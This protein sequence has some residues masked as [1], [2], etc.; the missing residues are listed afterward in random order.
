MKKLLFILSFCLLNLAFA[1]PA[2]AT[3]YG[4]G[5]KYSANENNSCNCPGSP[6]NPANFLGFSCC[7]WVEKN[8]LCVAQAPTAAPTN[9]KNTNDEDLGI[10]GEPVTEDTL[11]NLNPLLQQST[12]DQ[13]TLQDLSTPAGVINRVLTFLFPIAGFILF[14]MIVVG[15]FEM[16]SG[17][18]NKKSIESGKQRVV[19]AIVGFI[20]LFCA[21]WIAQLV[22]R[23]LGVRILG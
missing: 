23:I 11:N 9:N 7:G 15:G 21:Y 14:L 8:Y 3:V 10:V 4:C 6:S 13:K 5:Q 16:M 1:K 19:A 20:L 17:A 2:W 12:L 22:E 18:A